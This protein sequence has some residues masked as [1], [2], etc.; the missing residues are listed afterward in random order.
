MA[1]KLEYNEKSV[2]Y[3]VRIHADDWY[4][5]TFSVIMTPSL[6]DIIVMVSDKA[7]TLKQPTVA[8]EFAEYD[9]L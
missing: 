9:I 6:M 8:S 5:E 7:T 3:L 1:L 4:R 2:D